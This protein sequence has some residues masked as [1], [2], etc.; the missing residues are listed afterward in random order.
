MED[1]AKVL[2]RVR[3]LA[4]VVLLALAVGGARTLWSRS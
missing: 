4:V 3:V 2:R 1:D